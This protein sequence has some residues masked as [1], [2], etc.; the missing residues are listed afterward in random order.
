MKLVHEGWARVTD[1]ARAR[2]SR[3]DVDAEEADV[4]AELVNEE[5]FA[6]RGKR[7][8]WEP[9]PKPS[10]PRLT[11]FEG[12]AAAFQK[13]HAGRELR[14]TV[15][16][17]RDASALRVLLHLPDVHQMVTLRLA[18]V[19]APAESEPFGAEAKYNVELRL[20]QRDVRVRLQAVAPGPTNGVFVGSITHDAGN[21]A[22][23]LVSSAFARVADSAASLLGDGA[24][25]LRELE[26]AAQSKRLRIWR[27]FSE[28]STPASFDAIVVRIISGDTL[29]VHEAQGGDRELRLASVRVPRASD[30]TQGGY[31]AQA[32]D[33]LRRLCI[34]RTVTAAIEYRLDD[35]RDY[36][37]VRCGNIDLGV[38]VIERGLASAVHARPGAARA[39][40]YDELLAAEAHAREAHLGIH[41]GR[42]LPP[43]APVDASENATRA[44][45]FVANWQRV[46][47]VPCVVDYISGGARMRLLVDRDNARM[48]LVLAGIRCPRA[49][50]GDDTASAEPLG[51]EALALTTRHVLQRNAEVEIESVD[52]NGGFI[53]SLFVGG[54]QN[55]AETLLEHGLATVLPS[56]ADRSPHRTRLYAAE[57]IAKKARVGYWA[58]HDSS[59]V[60]EAPREAA[61]SVKVQPRIEFLDVAVSELVSPMSFF[62]QIAT[63]ASIAELES[64]MADLAASPP[65]APVTKFAPGPGQ[66]VC[67]CYTSGDQWHRARIVRVLPDKYEV[68]YV[69]FGNSETLSAARVRPLPA[70]FATK[71]PFAQAAQLAFLR[72]PVD[73]PD[74]GF[75]EGYVDAAYAVLRPL[76]EGRQLVANVEARPPNGPLQLTLYDPDL[77]RPVLDKSV[78][79]VVAAAGYAVA[80]LR[81]L[82]S[83]H[84]PNAAS[85]ISALVEDARSAHRGM[86]EYGDVTTDE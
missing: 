30:E 52:K 79:A 20:L 68:L 22:E 73:T 15:E 16:H 81:A 25:H 26:R 61:A 70:Q 82:S 64:M 2:A 50:R 78:N 59:V 43:P 58:T 63:P 42:P 13:K 39:A 12:D 27:D 62:V 11:T 34:G 60:E 32:R 57:E 51:A 45:A 9:K 1:N 48:T 19:R 14:A 85:T 47:R 33:A 6:R 74:S 86:W 7:G 72:L 75:V 29:V 18:G 40:A 54:R 4:V 69:D 55:W 23:W 41:S 76:L 35:S 38:Y 71:A 46:G 77:G 80:D 67:A 66:L 28:S 84:N 56:S 49:P 53:G 3:A 10:R 17:V 65:P 21:I 44:R 24:A 37:S 83:R 5:E 36:A 8:L 31:A